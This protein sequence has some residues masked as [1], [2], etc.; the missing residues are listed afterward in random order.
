MNPENLEARIAALERRVTCLER[1]VEMSRIINSN[2]DLEPLLQAIVQ[3]AAELTQAEGGSILLLD[4]QTGELHFRA[5]TGAKSEGIRHIPVPLN[6]SIAGQILRQNRPLVIEDAARDPRIY[7]QVDES[8]QFTTRSL[9]GVPL[10]VKDKSIGVLEVVNKIGN[11]GFTAEDVEVLSVLADQA[12][13][14]IENARLLAE[15]RRAYRELQELDRLKSEFLSIASHEL[16]TPLIT[17][18]GYAA[19]LEQDITGP[20]REQLALVRQSAWQLRNIIDDMV[21]LH[22]LETGQAPLERTRVLVQEI[23]AEVLEEFTPM[24]ESRRQTIAISL[25]G[26]PLSVLA[27]REKLYLALRNLVSNAVKFTP[28]GGQ[29]GIRV[30]EQPAETVFIVWDTG[31]GIPPRHQRRIF[32]RFY[33]A[34]PSLTRQ[35]G[36]LGLG[37]TIAREIVELHGGRIW[38]ESVVGQGSAFYMAIPH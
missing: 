35:H 37:L 20:A 26:V 14:A 24:A 38:V 17:I 8:S 6:G 36:G 4:R 19:L 34:E 1:I 23:V 22:H 27:D 12:A 7:R 28:E 30:E 3:A 13:I 31:P 32:D 2:L 10:R 15:L 33:Q 25:P 5:V 21:N 9:M 16:R 18:L 11:G 29:I